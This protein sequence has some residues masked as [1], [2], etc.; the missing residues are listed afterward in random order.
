[1]LI[2]G[3]KDSKS[4]TDEVELYEM[5]VLSKSFI[6]ENSKRLSKETMNP[7]F[8]VVRIQGA[9]FTIKIREIVIS[10]YRLLY[11]QRTQMISDVTGQ[12]QL[13]L[14]E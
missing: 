14:S 11:F 12:F 3:A 8:E 1:M 7:E 10:Y 9:F 2:T 6:E 13:L 5:I 4:I